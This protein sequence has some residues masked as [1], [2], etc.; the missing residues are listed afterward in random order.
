LPIAGLPELPVGWAVRRWADL[1][2]LA[3]AFADTVG[4]MCAR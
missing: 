4:A 1:T 2:P 3:R